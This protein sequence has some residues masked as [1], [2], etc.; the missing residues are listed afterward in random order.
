VARLW[1]PEFWQA[2]RQ[3]R[4]RFPSDHR[5]QVADKGVRRAEG[6]DRKGGLL[7]GKGVGTG[8]GLVVRSSQPELVACAGAV[9]AHSRVLAEVEHVEVCFC[10]CPSACLASLT[11]I[12]WQGSM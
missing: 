12:S 2:C 5:R 4:A 3:H 11:C 7:I 10:P 9:R 1:W 8:A 6:L